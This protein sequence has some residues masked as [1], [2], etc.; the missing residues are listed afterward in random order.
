[1]ENLI[2]IKINENNYSFDENISIKE[3]IIK[4]KEPY[5]ENTLV[6]KSF[7]SEK[8]EI[9]N[10]LR[11]KTTKGSIDIFLHDNQASNLLRN[12]IELFK[13]CKLG[14]STPN[15]ISFGKIKLTFNKEMISKESFY[16]NKFDVILFFPGFSPENCH[17]GFLKKKHENIYGIIKDPTDYIVGEIIRGETILENLGLDDYIYEI[18]FTRDVEKNFIRLE[19][20]ELKQNISENLE[21]YTYSIA[22]LIGNL[23][24]NLDHLFH[25]IENNVLKV[26]KTSNSYIFNKGEFLSIEKQNNL[27]R[28]KGAITLR[29]SG[30]KQGSLYIYKKNAPFSEAHNIIGEIKKGLPLILGAKDEDEIFLKI[31]PE[32]I[33][34]IGKTQKE[35]EEICK[36][37]NINLTRSGDKNDK[38]I[39]IMHEPSFTLD[40]LYSGKV[41]TFGINNNDILSISFYEEKA[42]DSAKYFKEVANMIYQDVGVLKISEKLNSFI[43]LQP[44]YEINLS[45]SFLDSE[46][47]PTTSIKP[48]HVGI[49]NS[50]RRLKGLIGIRL[51]ENDQYGPT[52]ED[53]TGTNLLGLVIENIDT[54]KTKNTGD[55]VYFIKKK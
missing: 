8:D 53:K 31:I 37:K 55:L 9:K 15:I 6:V 28:K 7:L 16:F 20:S 21:L 52:G 18:L 13:N 12:N 24:S 26:T 41:K 22:V 33:K 19:E 32:Q 14:W 3:A 34:L 44:F 46:N 10:V 48:G 35:A 17:I 1:M 51:T 54:L 45:E 42:T 39:V 38:S 43:L 50:M 5:K 49:T 29:N 36:K 4:S 27:F 25:I 47:N 30:Q 2:E 23:K 11:L 40:L